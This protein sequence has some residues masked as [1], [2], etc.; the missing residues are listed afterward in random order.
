MTTKLEHKPIHFHFHDPSSSLFKQ[1]ANARSEY[2][3]IKCCLSDCPLRNLGTCA[4]RRGL[5]GGSCPY[6]S[7]QRVEGPTRRANSFLKF[8]SDAKKKFPDVP[9]LNR[10]PEKMAFVGE[11]VYLPYSHM[12][13][14]DDVWG[15]TTSNLFKSG[16]DFICKE[17]WTLETVVSIINFR[18]EALFGGEIRA[19]QKESVPKFLTHLREC[20]PNMWSALVAKNP[21][22]DNQP[23]HVGRKA[24]LKTLK[25]PIKWLKPY[26]ARYPVLW[27]WDGEYLTTDSPHAYGST[28]GHVKADVFE[29]TLVPDETT[30]VEVQSN[31]WVLPTTKFQD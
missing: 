18:P 1:P 20:D 5:F 9:Y 16:S 4:I 31:D 26:D 30:V 28:W 19:Y 2:Q 6:G 15:N 7:M 23:N 12:N 27:S 25:S 22:L 29:I 13:M 11:Y 10:P 17:K 14:N 24:F 21:H 3:C 8:E